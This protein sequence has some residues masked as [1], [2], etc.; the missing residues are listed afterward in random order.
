MRDG[1]AFAPGVVVLVPG[2]LGAVTL[3]IAIGF[4]TV[5]GCVVF[6]GAVGFINGAV[7]SSA[8]MLTKK[9]KCPPCWTPRRKATSTVAPGASGESSVKASPS[10][11]DTDRL[12]L[13][14]PH[15]VSFSMNCC[16]S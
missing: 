2:C 9:R 1:D 4:F 13:S 8:S 6:V 5:T 11:P 16:S 3:G 14:P 12:L 10:P 7:V 15:C